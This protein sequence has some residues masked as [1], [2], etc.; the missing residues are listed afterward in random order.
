M[1]IGRSIRRRCK[2]AIPPIIFLALVAY[3]L[4]NATQGDRGLQ[5]AAQ[6]QAD[7]RAAQAELDR[8]K[9]D[10][11]VWERRVASLRSARLDQDAL[12]ER[13]RA[14]LNLSDPSDIIVSYGPGEHLF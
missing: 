7:V 3:F 5:A 14:I 13:V 2:A 12:D 8:A 4:W 11:Q 10:M 6:R 9:S 1:S